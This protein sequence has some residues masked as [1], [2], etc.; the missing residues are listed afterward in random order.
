[1]WRDL[2][3]CGREASTMRRPWPNRQSCAVG[4]KF[5]TARKLQYASPLSKPNRCVT[6][7]TFIN[8]DSMDFCIKVRWG[9]LPVFLKAG[10]ALTPISQHLSSYMKLDVL[11]LE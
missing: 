3:M 8:S 9:A 4:K 1:V 2:T 6:D 10:S 11:W 7:I 5:V